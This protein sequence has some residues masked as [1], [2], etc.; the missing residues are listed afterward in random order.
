MQTCLWN[1][2]ELVKNFDGLL[3]RLLLVTPR[4]TVLS[5]EQ[6]AESKRARLLSWYSVVFQMSGEV[7]QWSVT[8]AH[9]NEEG[10]TCNR[11]K[12]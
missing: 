3:T 6:H 4:R 5:K 7:T 10:A 1:S 11:T 12:V 2:S 8:A 9:R